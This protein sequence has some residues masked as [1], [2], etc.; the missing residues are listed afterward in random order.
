M[1][2]PNAARKLL[3]QAPETN[4]NPPNSKG[5]SAM[6]TLRRFAA[7]LCIAMFA[8]VTAV[9]ALAAT[10]IKIG[11]VVWIGYGPFYVADA[12]DLYKKSGYKV[13]L[14]VFNDPALIPPAIEAPRTVTKPLVPRENFV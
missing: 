7:V 14:Q 2:S 9:P 5:K 3:W 12:L 4:S 6:S 13:T 11:T 8:A 1:R 10:D